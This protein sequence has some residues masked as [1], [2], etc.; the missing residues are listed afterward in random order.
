[1][2][3]YARVN[4]ILYWVRRTMPCKSFFI[5][6]FD[7]IRVFFG[8]MNTCAFLKKNTMFYPMGKIQNKYVTATFYP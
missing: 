2:S 4:N 8:T 1:M 6:W 3:F 7:N 5:F